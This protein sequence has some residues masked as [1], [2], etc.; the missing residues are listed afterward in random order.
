MKT[1]GSLRRWFVLCIH[2]SPF[3]LLLVALGIPARSG[4]ASGEVWLEIDTPIPIPPKAGASAVYDPDRQRMIVFGGVAS[5]GTP[6][7][8]VWALDLTPLSE[9]WTPLATAGNRPAPRTQH[10]AVYDE[11]NQR[12]VIFGGRDSRG[13]LLNDVW[14]LDLA[15][16]VPQW[17]QLSAGAGPSLREEHTA[18]YDRANGRMIVFGGRDS[19]GSVNNDVWALNLTRESESWIQLTGL[20]VGPPQRRSHT[21]IYDSFN[22]RMITFAGVLS[23]N[24]PARDVWALDL[25]RGREGWAKIETRGEFPP[26][27][28]EMIA[29]YD[30][31]NQRMIVYG[32]VDSGGTVIGQTWFLDLQAGEATWSVPPGAALAASRRDHVAVYDPR[33]HRLVTATGLGSGGDERSD[34]RVLNLTIDASPGLRILSPEAGATIDSSSVEVQVAIQNFILDPYRVDRG[35]DREDFGHWHLLLDGEYQTF[36]LGTRGIEATLTNLTPGGHTIKVELANNQHSL[37]GVEDEVMITIPPQRPSIRIV[38]PED[39][40]MTFDRDITVQVEVENINLVSPEGQPPQP[41]QGHYHIRVDGQDLGVFVADRSYTIRNLTA[42]EHRITVELQ[43]N[44]HLPFDPPVLDTVVMRILSPRIRILAPQAGALINS[45]SIEVRVDIRDFTLD[46][47]RVGGSNEAGF[48]HWHL[49]LDGVYQGFVTGTEG[50]EA[51]LTELE[52]GP[53]AIRVELAN[54]DHSPLP[55]AEASDEVNITITEGRPAIRLI[56]PKLP[57][58]EVPPWNRKVVIVDSDTL[59]VVIAV[60]HFVLDAEGINGPPVP[61]HG[62]WHLFVDGKLQLQTAA[63]SATAT[64]LTPGYHRIVVMLTNNNHTELDPP[65]IDTFE[66][67]RPFR[68]RLPL[69][70]R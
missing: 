14:A 67:L 19:G 44:H 36:V 34:V 37:L 48:G 30:P 35:P 6:Q 66:V 63:T 4:F 49:F 61:G 33:D 2:F 16:S 31:L 47:D 50:F 43:D 23:D 27:C 46:P 62:H 70:S 8:D 28:I 64:G 51:T 68:L 40:F 13:V 15:G 32:G 11:V 12:M 41:G 3:F 20:G 56:Q 24:S 21:A 22:Q 58:R 26:N 65:V 1:Q 42:G 59:D 55:F 9:N 69:V 53:H 57:D 29:A 5:D 10:T 38:S 25:R 60:E 18:I 39:G 45:S 52:P 7:S 17:M 54:N